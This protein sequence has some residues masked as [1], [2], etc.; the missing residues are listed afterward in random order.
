[1]IV[2]SNYKAR[3]SW[4]QQHPRWKIWRNQHRIPDFLRARPRKTSLFR[5]RLSWKRRAGFKRKPKER[6]GGSRWN[7]R[8]LMNQALRRMLQI[9]RSRPPRCAPHEHDWE[10]DGVNPEACRRC[11]IS[12]L[13]HIYTEMP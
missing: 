4:R 2:V 12:F 7:S 9:E 10:N 13:N 11:G 5:M 3:V 1:M 6:F 8:R